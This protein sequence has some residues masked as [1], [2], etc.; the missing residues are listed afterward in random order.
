MKKS[1]L[2]LATL[3]CAT[4]LFTAC[5]K[6]PIDV[7]KPIPAIA[8]TWKVAPLVSNENNEFV[9]G[10]L[11]FAWVAPEGTML[12]GFLDINQLPPLLNPLGG[13][14]V[15]QVLRD[16]TFHEDGAI[17]ATYSDAGISM[18]SETVI[19]PSWKDSGKGYLT[20]TE[21]EGHGLDSI[22]I[23]LNIEKI[24]NGDA[25]IGQILAQ[26]PVLKNFIDNGIPMTV[27]M[28]TDKK[29]LSMFIDKKII[30][31]LLPLIEQ[32]LPMIPDDGLEGMAP[33][34]KLMLGS[35]PEAMAVTT[36]FELGIKLQK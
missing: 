5:E 30:M 8:G 4:T 31:Q 29:A 1:L 27:K 17:S 33:L 12:G 16:V 19:T 25:S 24:A 28:S 18:G 21:V 15:S 35:L 14:V 6:K 7:Q 2:Y 36:Q 34:I 9:S 20:Y 11:H 10:P 3:V 23:H 32:F 22:L 13:I 26:F